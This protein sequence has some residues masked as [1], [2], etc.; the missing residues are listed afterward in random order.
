M[1][2]NQIIAKTFSRSVAL[3]LT[4]PA[5]ESSLGQVPQATRLNSQPSVEQ[6]DRVGRRGLSDPPLSPD[7]RISAPQSYTYR[8]ESPLRSGFV[9]RSPATLKERIPISMN[10][11]T[12]AL[13]L[14]LLYPVA[15]AAAQ[16]TV[17][18]PFD[19]KSLDGW[20]GD[21]SFWAVQDGAIVGKSTAEHPLP[22]S[23]Y[24]VWG[25]DMPQDFDLRCKVL[26]TAGNSG[27]QY[28]SHRVD[29][30]TDMAGF[31]ADLDAAN[32]YTGI[33]YEGL[34]REIMS[35]RGEQVEWAPA[36]KRVVANFAPDAILKGVMRPGEW[37][38][39][40]VEARGTRVRHWING[41]LMTDVTDGDASRFTRDGLLGFQL[42][43]GA[44]M[45]VRWKELEVR[46]ITDAPSASALTVPDGFT[47]QLVTSA[48]HNQGSWVSLAFDPRGRAVVS[49][50][51]G[52]TLRIEIP[53]TTN[54]YT[55][56]E[57]HVT[58]LIDVPGSAQGLC[59]A[60][61]DLWVDSSAAGPSAGLWQLPDKDGDGIYEKQRLVL[62]WKGD[63]GEH[64]PHGVV[65]GPDG[66]IYVAIG[67]HTAVPEGVS[68]GV[69]RPWA[70]DLV[71]E[72]MWDPRGHAVGIVAPGG[73]VL[74]IDPATGAVSVFASGFRNHYDLAFNNDGELFTY[75]S[76]MEW[77]IGTPWYRAPRIVHVVN[78]G[79]YG[80]RSG[81][82]CLPSW[83]PDTLPPVCETDSSSPTGML[84]GSGGA[85]PTP[86]RNML[87]AADWT[88]GRIIAVSLT[89]SGST[90]TGA[91]QPFVTGRPM[92][93]TDMAW[94]PD[95]A[96]YVLT[97]GRGTQ[98]GLYRITA[99]KPLSSA[100]RSDLAD[101]KN[102]PAR[103]AR[104]ALEHLSATPD[105]RKLPSVVAALASEDR[106]TAFAARNALEA[107]GSLVT[108]QYTDTPTPRVKAEMILASVRMPNA[109]W[110][111]AVLA[112]A[113]IG[114]QP[115]ADTWKQ[116]IALRAVQIA[117][118]RHSD[119]FKGE[120]GTKITAAAAHL[121]ERFFNH[122][123]PRIAEAAL[124]IA[125]EMG[126]S[127]A[128][129][130]AMDR[131]IRASDRSDALRWATMLRT[132]QSGWNNELRTA[133]WNWLDSANDSSGGF[134]LRGFID[135]VKSDA[136]KYVHRPEGSTASNSATA[137]SPVTAGNSG[138][139][140]APRTI[141]A[142]NHAWTVTELSSSNP[143]DTAPD[144]ARGAQLFRE[145]MCIQCHRIGGQG[146]ANGP[147]LT[148]VG[149]RF[150]RTDLL[151]AI[152]EPNAAVS[153]QWRD[154][155]ITL[156]DGGMVIGRIVGSDAES[157]TIS[158]NPLG[159]ERD[160][161]IR[162]EIV[163]SEPVTTSSMPQGMLNARTRQEIIDML[164][165]LE[166]AGI[167]A[168]RG[169]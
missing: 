62:Q 27:I 59:F 154:T 110:T 8:M 55:G 133:Y 30:R 131:L 89:A 34:G 105:A 23:G 49:P 47:V 20:D 149:S 163:N 5:V 127:E 19:G 165:Y 83:M 151:R 143:S 125:C 121:A 36:G 115:D 166:T 21:R 107:A 98:S 1:L 45:E 22:A 40:R 57:V 48:Q 128:V 92:P 50:Q 17:L 160:R 157:L 114:E 102:A 65:Q 53:A 123:D 140:P 81:S 90:Y 150:A 29:G 26:I 158:T 152:L 141:G 136:E 66:A 42:H 85:F 39:Y 122:S 103:A 112:A 32:S 148:G 126:R 100:D 10:A 78:G 7:I 144:H 155:A 119:D 159:P 120:H 106:F 113:A 56:T 70:E 95:G 76:D 44:P 108:K 96:M 161:V 80:W 75:D 6:S 79:E 138:A 61:N 111:S 84:Y 67:N 38:D 72:R 129:A 9:A 124:S 167:S 91:W 94:G 99:E 31:Q 11:T 43:Q 13:L 4:Y 109:D 41:T 2:A 86:W 60:G 139:T 63:G 12:A 73:T 35:G 69:C 93:V 97:G 52:K 51:S 3:A 137:I 101:V 77:D 142:V 132:V 46:P 14:S 116:L 156:K 15:F 74:R 146:G 28:R 16:D 153:D 37:N 82:G 24:L 164:G 169:G 64:G 88:Y 145:A 18:R 135:Q 87:F 25:G 71:G 33:L 58:E 54:G 104:R 162:T 68:S 147:D 118:A 117:W 130:P 168:G 134:S